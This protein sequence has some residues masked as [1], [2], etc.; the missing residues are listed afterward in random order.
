MAIEIERRF[1][2]EDNKWKSLIINEQKIRQCYL[3]SNIEEWTIRL[4]IIDNKKALLTLKKSKISFSRYE[5]EYFIPID[6]AEQIWSLTPFRIEKIRHAINL[7]NGLWIVD[8]FEGRN[9]PLIIAEVEIPK[10]DFRIQKPH[11]CSTEITYDKKWSNAALAQKPFSEWTFK[12]KNK[13][14]AP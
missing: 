9:Y 12:E 3:T 13:P 6:E 4:R 2:V 11:W 1:L 7:D 8:S 10:E 14:G 5:F